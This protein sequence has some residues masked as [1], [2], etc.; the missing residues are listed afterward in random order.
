M[1]DCPAV[2]Y[3]RLSAMRT[4]VSTGARRGQR[5]PGSVASRPPSLCEIVAA[6]AYHRRQDFATFGSA[7][8]RWA[9]SDWATR[10]KD[11]STATEDARASYGIHGGMAFGFG[12]SDGCRLVQRKGPRLSGCPSHSQG[13]PCLSWLPLHALCCCFHA[14]FR[15]RW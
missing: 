10:D 3:Y 5:S 14:Y 15:T 7:L 9:A 1:G 8:Y 13:L 12:N 2:T 6:G 11:Y 4:Y